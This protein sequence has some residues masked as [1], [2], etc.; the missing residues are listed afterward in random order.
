M[1]IKIKHPNFQL[2]I[3]NF[4]VSELENAKA[5][6][7]AGRPIKKNTNRAKGREEYQYD[8]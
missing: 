1:K 8:L 2:S 4:H 7:K 6:G 5:Y 3:F